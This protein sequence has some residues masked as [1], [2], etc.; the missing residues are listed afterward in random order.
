MTI[1]PTPVTAALAGIASAILWPLAWSRFGG[2][3]GGFSIESILATL[4]LIAVPAHAF[5]VGFGYRSAPGGRTLDV[6]LLKRLGAWLLAAGVTAAA[7][8][9]VRSAQ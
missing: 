5:V 9:L 3:S 6:A 2:A 7:M 1:Q 4:L 8:G